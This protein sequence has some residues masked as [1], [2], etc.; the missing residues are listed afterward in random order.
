MTLLPQQIEAFSF[1][2]I[3]L[4]ICIPFLLFVTTKPRQRIQR[5]IPFIGSITKA[6][7]LRD[8]ILGSSV[9]ERDYKIKFLPLVFLFLMSFSSMAQIPAVIPGSDPAPLISPIKTEVVIVYLSGFSPK[10]EAR[11]K[12]IVRKTQIVINLPQFQS[13]VENFTFNGEK[14]FHFTPDSTI[15]VFQKITSQRWLLEYKLEWIWAKSTIGYTMKSVSWIALNSRRFGKMKDSAVAANICHEFGGHKLG[16]Y[17]HEKQ[18]N[19]KRDFSVPYGIGTICGEL[20]EEL[21]RSTLAPAYT[22][23]ISSSR[24]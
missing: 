14:R 10:E 16:S 9:V 13:R 24:R 22:R 4:M 1:G 8:G 6:G 18:W 17:D 19:P 2:F 21:T 11:F 7:V 15:K 5:T 12:E 20:Y 3:G 23:N